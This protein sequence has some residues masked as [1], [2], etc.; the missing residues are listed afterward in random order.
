MATF[1][2]GERN[3]TLSNLWDNLPALSGENDATTTYIRAALLGFVGGLRSMTPFAMLNRTRELDPPPNST[4]EQIL[5][6]PVTRTIT[7]LLASGELVGDKLP[8]IPNRISPVPLLGRVGLGALAGMSI[9]RRYQQSLL[10]GALLGAVAA[11]AGYIAVKED[12][13]H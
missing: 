11:G 1:H 7:D 6:S 12:S 9:C 5:T 13:E 4:I 8:Q 10:L 2:V 3:I